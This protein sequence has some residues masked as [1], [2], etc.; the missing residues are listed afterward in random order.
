MGR[1]AAG[2]REELARH[3][4]VTTLLGEAVDLDADAR[5]VTARRP[6]ESTFTLDYD[7]LIV[8]VGAVRQMI[9]LD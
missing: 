8:A 1:S 6:D 7:V 2:L 9:L 5:Q 4:N 3:H